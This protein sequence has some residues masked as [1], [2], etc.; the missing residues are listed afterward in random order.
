[1]N[2]RAEA[3]AQDQVAAAATSRQ[4]NRARVMAQTPGGP[5]DVTEDI[6]TLLDAIHGSMDWGSGFLNREDLVAW[7]TLADLLGFD[8]VAVGSAD[9]AIAELDR[10][11]QRK[12]DFTA[13]WAQRQQ[14]QEGT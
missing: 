2:E 7:K 8:A 12:R 1:M 13:E 3:D 5:R 14:V 9:E 6:V 4:R 11:E 10:E